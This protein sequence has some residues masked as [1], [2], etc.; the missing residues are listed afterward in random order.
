[1]LEKPRLAEPF[2]HRRTGARIRVSIQIPARDL[3]DVLWRQAYFD[4]CALGFLI[5]PELGIAR[6]K[7]K[8][9]VCVR[10]DA[11]R[12]PTRPRS[13]PRSVEDDRA[14]GLCCRARLRL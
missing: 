10:P 6:C 8:R 1:M 3:R 12:C 5:A 11:P 14:R 13:P 4:Q 9:A 2:G 7:N